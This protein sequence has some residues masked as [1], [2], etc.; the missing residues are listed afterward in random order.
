MKPPG[1]TPAKALATRAARETI[2]RV[3]MLVS[4]VWKDTSPRRD[5]LPFIPEVPLFAPFA[6]RLNRAAE[7][8]LF[9]RVSSPN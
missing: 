6:R 1:G 2:A 4:V 8:D 3:F 9:L 7:K 5:R